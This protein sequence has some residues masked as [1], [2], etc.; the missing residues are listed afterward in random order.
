M[1]TTIS[2]ATSEAHDSLAE[3]VIQV[4]EEQGYDRSAAEDI[5]RGG[6]EATFDVGAVLHILMRLRDDVVQA[7]S[8]TATGWGR[9]LET[10]MTPLGID[11]G[12]PE[13]IERSLRR[14]YRNIFD[15]EIHR[16]CRQHAQNLARAVC[17]P[18][19]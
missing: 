9:R 1:T 11:F 16:P 8:E 14:H 10:M 19:G 17:D 4:I 2:I 6:A 3:V 15:E 12:D 7:G 5:V 18:R 13:D